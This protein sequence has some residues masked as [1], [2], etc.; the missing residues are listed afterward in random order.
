MLSRGSV[1]RIEKKLLG[2]MES[3][4]C[5]QCAQR[6]AR[7]G[8]CGRPVGITVVEAEQAREGLLRWMDRLGG[9]SV[10]AA[11]SSS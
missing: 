6:S 11:P 9:G 7:C 1:D 8:E 2:M 10:A 3:S 4:D 5:S